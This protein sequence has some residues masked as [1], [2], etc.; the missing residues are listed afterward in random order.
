MIDKITPDDLAKHL[1]WLRGEEGGEQLS[2]IWGACLHGADLRGAELRGAELRGADLHGAELRNADLHGAD[3]RGA[4]MYDVDLRGAD[5]HGADLHCADL[6]G[7][8]L[9]GA[10]MYGALNIPDYVSAVTKI[11]PEGDIVV[12]KKLRARKIAKL[13]IPAEAKRSN[14]TG[15][16]CR[17]EFAEVLSIESV[18]GKE[19]FE[20]GLSKSDR[21]FTYKVGEIVRPDSFDEDRWDE[22]SHGIYFFLTRHEAE[23]YL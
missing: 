7:A 17:A 23:E 8:D 13:R 14:A 18:D 4:K 5:L 21:N 9:R 10:K 11:V 1:A 19:N 20:E 16:K 22:C 15:R 12:Y 3:L 6:H 2:V